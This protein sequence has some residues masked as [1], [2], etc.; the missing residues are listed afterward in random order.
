MITLFGIS[1]CDTVKKAK[2]QLES[3]GEDFQFHDF[4]KDGLSQSQVSAWLKDLGHDTLINKRSRT[5]KELTDQQQK[6]AMG[7]GAAKL[8]VENP[9]LIKRPVLEVS[10][11]KSV[12]QRLVGF[13]QKAYKA[14]SK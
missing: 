1:N 4:R 14:L 8:I 12:K 7:T 6:L 5:W 10:Q 3:Q 9:T 13:D 11:G 2:K